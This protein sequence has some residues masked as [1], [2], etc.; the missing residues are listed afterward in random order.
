MLSSPESLMLVIPILLIELGI[1]IFALVHM[2]KNENL[3]GNRIMWIFLILLVS[4]FGWLAYFIF[5]TDRNA[6]DG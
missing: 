3:R 6:H 1:R 5:G 4:L 2:L